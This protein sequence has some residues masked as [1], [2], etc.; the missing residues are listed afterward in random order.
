MS[1]ARTLLATL[2]VVGSLFLTSGGAAAK[3]GGPGRGPGKQQKPH[4]TWSTPR[5]EQTVSPGQTVEVSVTLTS[6]A[7][8]TNL[9]F[10]VSGGLREMLTVEPTSTTSLKA[11]VAT[12]VKLIITMPATGAHNQGGVIQVRAGQR[13]LPSAFKVKLTVPGTA[14]ESED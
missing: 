1:I 13:N 12:P 4:L 9:T 6:S 14:E 3:E 10:Q 7:D 5:L 11:G 8:L 2:V